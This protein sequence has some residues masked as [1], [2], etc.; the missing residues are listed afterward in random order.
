MH[1]V[2]QPAFH[3]QVRIQEGILRFRR[4]WD[5]D[6]VPLCASSLPDS[7]Y[8]FDLHPIGIDNSTRPSTDALLKVRSR[9]EDDPRSKSKLYFVGGFELFGWKLEAIVTLS[10]LTAARTVICIRLL[11][12]GLSFESDALLFSS[13]ASLATLRRWKN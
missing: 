3:W 9:Q 8:A 10:N 4:I 5:I 7:S 6:G 1:P 12:K 2:P 13:K 11:R